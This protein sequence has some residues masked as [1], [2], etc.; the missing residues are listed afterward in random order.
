MKS[1]C[2]VGLVEPAAD[3]PRPVAGPVAKD[4]SPVSSTMADTMAL[5][6][7]CLKKLTDAQ[8]TKPQPVKKVK[9]LLCQAEEAW[10]AGSYWDVCRL[11]DRNMRKERDSGLLAPASFA[12]GPFQISS[13]GP[14]RSVP[15]DL[16]RVFDW[17]LWLEGWHRFLEMVARSARSDRTADLIA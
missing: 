11:C 1:V 2:P 5:L 9:S 13:S 8:D 6:A 12:L 15:K 7:Q 3:V 17:D 10:L 14:E 16:S 4:P